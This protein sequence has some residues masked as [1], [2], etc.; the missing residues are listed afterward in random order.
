M[1]NE[2]NPRLLAPR[3]RLARMAAKRDLRLWAATALLAVRSKENSPEHTAELRDNAHE[4]LH[5]LKIS[6]LASKREMNIL[7][8]AT[9]LNPTFPD[10]LPLAGT[11]HLEAE[12]QDACRNAD[13]DLGLHCTI[14]HPGG[15]ELARSRLV[16]LN[17]SR[18]SL[19]AETICT[20]ANRPFPGVLS[21]PRGAQIMAPVLGSNASESRAGKE[22]LKSNVG[23]C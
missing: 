23:R 20:S 10:D 2:S 6:A 18:R 1:S 4:N 8:S 3:K 19:N 7:S 15:G 11:P 14:D 16:S 13:R 17:V 5:S 12:S 9:A 22:R 21:R